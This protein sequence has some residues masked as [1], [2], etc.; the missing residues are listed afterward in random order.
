VYGALLAFALFAAPP[1]P[2]AEPTPP[3]QQ[4]PAPFPEPTPFPRRPVRNLPDPA[5]VPSFGVGGAWGEDGHERS[6]AGAH[7]YAGVN[8]HPAPS[9]FGPFMG[10]GGSFD[11]VSYRAGKSV[12]VETWYGTAEM[13]YGV[14]FLSQPNKYAGALFPLMT[15][16][17]IGG[18]RPERGTSGLYR[19]GGGIGSPML[20]AYSSAETCIPVPSMLEVVLDAP[21]GKFSGPD[22]RTS[23]RAGWQF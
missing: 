19:A 12:T 21:D 1:S 4:D 10:I 23:V 15:V 22:T 7:L 18:W 13:R 3:P 20:V 6:I 16:Y 17:G 14:A 11:A 2:D 9:H 5:L 8:L